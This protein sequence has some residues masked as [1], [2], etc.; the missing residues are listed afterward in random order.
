VQKEDYRLSVRVMSGITVDIG[1]IATVTHIK[2]FISKCIQPILLVCFRESHTLYVNMPVVLHGVFM[3][4]K[5]IFFLSYTV[6][7]QGSQIIWCWHWKDGVRGIMPLSEI[8]NPVV[9]NK[10]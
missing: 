8:W 10:R 7:Q 9:T 4:V 6:N 2:I 5:G 3:M 1:P